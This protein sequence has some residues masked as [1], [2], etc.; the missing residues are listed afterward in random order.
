MCVLPKPCRNW[1]RNEPTRSPGS[2]FSRTFGKGKSPLSLFRALE[3]N[4]DSDPVVA[5]WPCGPE[6]RAGSRAV[7]RLC[8]PPGRL[9]AS[10][11]QDS[12]KD[13]GRTGYES[14][15]LLAN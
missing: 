9:R 15:E 8:M 1:K 12:G 11:V 14:E 10:W 13:I 4:T 6:S 3:A 5:L 2:L 7:V